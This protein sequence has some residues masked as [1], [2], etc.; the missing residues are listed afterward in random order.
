MGHNEDFRAD[1]TQKEA[2][3]LTGAALTGAPTPLT[4]R[5][6]GNVDDSLNTGGLFGD[7]SGWYRPEFPDGAWNPVDLPHTAAAPGVTWYRTTVNPHLPAGQDTSVGLRI[8]DDPARPYRAEIFVNGWQ[9]G[10]YI[11]GVG[12]QHSFPIPNGILRPD[13]DNTI[14]IA[15]WSTGTGGGLGTVRLEA[16]GT[17]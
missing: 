14:A 5:I 6:Q 7:R 10:R 11:N 17:Q 8:D 4:W 3:G 15:V 1:D 9:L 12:P 13:G 2:R 16:Y